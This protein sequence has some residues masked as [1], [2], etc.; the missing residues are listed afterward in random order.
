MNTRLKSELN[1][2]YNEYFESKFALQLLENKAA[3]EAVNKAS[4][5]IYQYLLQHKSTVICLIEEKPEILHELSDSA[6]YGRLKFD[7]ITPEHVYAK[8]CH[9]LNDADTSLAVIMQVHSV[10]IYRIFQLTI[11]ESKKILQVDVLFSD[12]GRKEKTDGALYSNKVGICRNR[13]FCNMTNKG[14]STDKHARALDKFINDDS[15]LYYLNVCAKS[16]PYVAGPSTHTLTL[17]SGAIKL[18]LNQ[19]ED[20]KE[21]ALACFAFLASGGNHCFHEVMLVA[22]KAGFQ[23]DDGIYES[24]LPTS[25]IQSPWYKKLN[26][27]F[28]VGFRM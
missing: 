6:F 25:V 21:Y 23:Y 14:Y 19:I 27:E 12:R 16:I 2:R 26:E 7:E 10:F 24:C 20:I 9:V 18:G 8:I 13:F 28:G 4:K 5:L 11:E 1:I 22:S 17:I 15:S 3:L